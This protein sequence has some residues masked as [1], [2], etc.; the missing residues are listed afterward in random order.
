MAT[1]TAVGWMM[2]KGA[3]WKPYRWD[4]GLGFRLWPCSWA[5]VQA[6]VLQLGWG[7]D[8]SPAKGVMWSYVHG[9][10]CGA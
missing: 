4:A 2:T 10:R 3:C 8:C 5:G 9:T 7:S 1:T 6:A